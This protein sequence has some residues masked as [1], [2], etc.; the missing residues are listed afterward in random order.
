MS[1]ESSARTTANS[2]GHSMRGLLNLAH[3]FISAFLRDMGDAARDHLG[4]HIGGS[5]S[6]LYIRI[7]FTRLSAFL[8]WRERCVGFGHHRAAGAVEV[9][10]GRF[11]GVF[12]VEP[13]SV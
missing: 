3:N 8:E 13:R 1:A 12:C 2:T 9:F 7:P 11:Q 5:L 6:G 4:N 10:V